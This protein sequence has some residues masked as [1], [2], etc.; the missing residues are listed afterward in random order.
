MNLPSL[1]LAHLVPRS[2]NAPWEA[3]C[4]GKGKESV[5]RAR[6]THQVH[7]EAP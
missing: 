4:L 3:E 2:T 5:R 1:L 6:A 7:T